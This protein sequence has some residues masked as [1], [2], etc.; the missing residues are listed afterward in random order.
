MHSKKTKDKGDK[1]QSTDFR[2]ATPGHGMFEM[3]KKCCAGGGGFPD[4]SSEMESI[5]EAMTKQHCCTPNEDAAES[6]RRKK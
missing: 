2:F 3:M 4:C 1:A 5:M 6:Q